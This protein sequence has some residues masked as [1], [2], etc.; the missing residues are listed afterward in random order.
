MA[1]MHPA[2]SRRS[3]VCALEFDLRT[4]WPSLLCWRCA[5][6]GRQTWLWGAYDFCALQMLNPVPTQFAVN[7]S[8]TWCDF[9]PSQTR[10]LKR[11]SNK[12]HL[13][14]YLHQHERRL[15]HETHIV[16]DSCCVFVDKYHSGLDGKYKLKNTD[17]II[18]STEDQQSLEKHRNRPSDI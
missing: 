8:K 2:P 13:K 3:D 17:P 16:S 9:H 10:E 4:R 6:S 14:I 12:S 7:I 1:R 5:T 15:K 11:A 18:E